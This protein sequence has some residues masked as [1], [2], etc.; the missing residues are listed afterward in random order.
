MLLFSLGFGFFFGEEPCRDEEEIKGIIRAY[1]QD[2]ERVLEEYRTLAEQYAM[3]LE[4]VYSDS[5]QTPQPSEEVLQY[6]T[7]KAALERISRQE[8]YDTVLQGAIRDLEKTAAENNSEQA[9]INRYLLEVYEQ[10]RSLRLGE[11]NL[12]GLESLYAMIGSLYLPLMLFGI[13]LGVT[14][15][16]S[17]RERG[18]EL[19]IYATGKG[20]TPSFFAKLAVC[21]LLC[22]AVCAGALLL[23][24]GGYAYKTGFDGFSVYIQAQD[25]FALFPIPMTVTESL[26]LLF[27]LLFAGCM[28]FCGIACFLGMHCRNRLTPLAGASLLLFSNVLQVPPQAGT[29]LRILPLSRLV[30]GNLIFDHLYP[31]VLLGKPIYGVWMV[32]AGYIACLLSFWGLFVFLPKKA[33]E[34]PKKTIRLPQRSRPRKLHS[35][36]VY[37]WKK[38]LFVGKALLL[39]VAA[40]V[41]KIFFA[42]MLFSYDPTY[43]NEKYR[44]YML[45]L[46]GDFTE[47]K[48]ARVEKELADLNALFEM[49]EEMEESYRTGTVTREEMGKYLSAFYEAQHT[50]E[51]LGM[52]KKRMV[53]LKALYDAGENA[54][55]VY[56]TGWERLL[57]PYEDFILMLLLI[58]GFCG[59]VSQEHRRGMNQLYT[60]YAR[61]KLK[62]AKLGFC[63]GF[64]VLSVVLFC[65]IDLAILLREYPLPSGFSPACGIGEVPFLGNIPLYGVYAFR[66][67]QKLFYGMGMGLSVCALSKLTKSKIL[68]FII[69]L[70]I[71]VPLTTLLF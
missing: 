20:G 40:M 17:Q 59:T 33:V 19:L 44:W 11:G 2:P 18:T 70:A 6:E 12:R 38:Q 39:L 60:S 61:S 62:K 26:L 45:S 36:A 65:G 42:G 5:L 10:N 1:R 24:V 27:S 51:A 58:T 15:V 22:G 55:I 23:S 8:R 32:L 48:Y 50:E 54:V 56:D 71:F 14:L 53:A 41:L 52:V 3:Y 37:E 63:I 69:A 4:L 68:T 30:D 9:V 25:S 16:F 31:I 35:V 64:T 47:E 7:Y 13:L 21:T 43:T 67:L 49:R 46:Q 66:I 28:T 34:Q 57:T 29:L